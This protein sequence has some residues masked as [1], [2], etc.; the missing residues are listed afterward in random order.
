MFI[1][2][3]NFIAVVQILKWQVV[4]GI[5]A[6]LLVSAIKHNI[7]S[8]VSALLGLLCVLLPT[9][10]YIRV[11]FVKQV[12]AAEN[13]LRLHKKAMLLKFVSN[14]VLFALV[15]LFYKKCDVMILF[16][17]YIF[18]ISGYWFSLLKVS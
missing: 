4:F 2:N 13:M 10:I 8:S 5:T 7:N 14:L 16:I 18:S 12:L 15:F 1:N 6:I 11:A 17:T 3:K 9:I